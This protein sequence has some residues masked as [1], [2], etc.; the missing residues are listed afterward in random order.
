MSTKA[1]KQVITAELWDTWNEHQARAG[2]A[3]LLE[4]RTDFKTDIPWARYEVQRVMHCSSNGRRY[5]SVMRG[6]A[7]GAHCRENIRNL[8]VDGVPVELPELGNSVAQWGNY[9]FRG[10]P[11]ALKPQSTK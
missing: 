3:T 11:L 7:S 9:T 4:A 5:F 10:E 1:V 2:V 6:G 8:C